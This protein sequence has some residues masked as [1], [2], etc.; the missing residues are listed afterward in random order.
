V[1]EASDVAELVHWAEG[2]LEDHGMAQEVSSPKLESVAGDYIADGFQFFV[3]DLIEVTSNPRSIEPIIYRFETDFLYYPLV[4]SS[5]ASGE[6]EISLFLLTP[7]LINL[8]ELPMGMT[9]GLLYGQPVRFEING[10][11]LRSIDSEI[12]ELLGESAWLTAVKYEGALEA[13]GS[14]LKLYS[15]CPTPELTFRSLGGN[16]TAGEGSTANISLWG[17]K[18][19]FYGSVIAPTPCHELEAELVIPSNLLYPQGIIVNITAYDR[20]T[21][22]IQCLG[23]IPFTGEIEHLNPGEYDIIIIYQGQSLRDVRIPPW[24]KAGKCPHV[25]G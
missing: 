9:I 18:V 13:L 2:F 24:G 6:T 20:G 11:E 14:D 8:A 1:V 12:A 3:F 17:N 23:E 15:G 5:L 4:I 25:A 7:G 16:C 19:L 21:I 10:E 22:C